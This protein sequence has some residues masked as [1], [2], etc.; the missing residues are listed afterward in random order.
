MPN[1]EGQYPQLS[2]IRVSVK[3][4]QRYEH[5]EKPPGSRD[6]API[7]DLPKNVIAIGRARAA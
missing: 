7:E 3:S 5:P 4:W 1:R 2:G 6:D